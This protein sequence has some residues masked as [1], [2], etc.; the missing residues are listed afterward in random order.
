MYC[1]RVIYS[2]A[3]INFFNRMSDDEKILKCGSAKNSD[4]LKLYLKNADYSHQS[5][6]GIYIVINNGVEFDLPHTLDKIIIVPLKYKDKIYQF[7]DHEMIHI[8]F[9]YHQPQ[10][11]K[12]F[13][14]KV[15][16]VNISQ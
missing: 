3:L 15:G 7:I 8:Y 14:N 16:I 12:N 11:I 13:C 4:M 5:I 9:R 2:N 1:N 10:I 6:Q